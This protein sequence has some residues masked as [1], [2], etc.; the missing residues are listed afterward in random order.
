MQRQAHTLAR[1]SS[2]FNSGN[3]TAS[4]EIGERPFLFSGDCPVVSW[5]GGGASSDQPPKEKTVGREVTRRAVE[6]DGR[7]PPRFCRPYSARRDFGKISP[8]Q[9]I[10]ASPDPAGRRSLTAAQAATGFTLNC[11]LGF[12]RKRPI[13]MCEARYGVAQSAFKALCVPRSVFH[14][15]CLVV[16]LA[17][18]GERYALFISNGCAVA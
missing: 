12:R 6:R 7:P 11:V 10:G 4:Y 5:S 9:G 15:R 18:Y 14:R 16:P 8:F 1:L 17:R 3:L 2:Y 13:F